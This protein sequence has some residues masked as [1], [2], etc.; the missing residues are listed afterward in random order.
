MTIGKFSGKNVIYFEHMVENDK[1]VYDVWTV[2]PLIL[3]INDFYN[4]YYYLASIVC[5]VIKMINNI[6][7]EFKIF[8]LVNHHHRVIKPVSSIF[9]RK[10]LLCRWTLKGHP[11]CRVVKGGCIAECARYFLSRDRI[12]MLCFHRNIAISSAAPCCMCNL[13]VVCGDT[14][15]LSMGCRVL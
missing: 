7:V 5:I 8:C 4:F 12:H 6:F 14:S 15:T 11:R 9:L 2:T 10:T 3:T 13:Y 1:K